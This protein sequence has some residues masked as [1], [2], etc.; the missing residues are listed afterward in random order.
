MAIFLILCRKFIITLLFYIYIYANT[1][2]LN[3]RER[4]RTRMCQICI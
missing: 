1:Q 3:E 4:E 2:T